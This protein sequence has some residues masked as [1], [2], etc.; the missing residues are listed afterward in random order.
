MPKSIVTSNTSQ[1]SARFKRMARNLPGVVDKSIHDL[2][3]DEALPLFEKTTATWNDKPEFL[4]V[5]TARGYGVRVEPQYPW[6]YVNKGTRA[7]PIE[8]RNV[9]LLRFTGPYHA[10]TKVNV[11]SSYHGGRGRVWVS[12]RMV[13]H[14]GIEARNFSDIILKRVQARAANRV[15]K[16]LSDASYGAGTGI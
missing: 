11:I 6:D 7:H 16:D 5:K 10:K 2:V 15:R 1:V 4:V 3:E 14:P 9:P 12:K 8:A 13:Q